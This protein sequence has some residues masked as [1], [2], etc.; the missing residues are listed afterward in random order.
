MIVI[1]NFW[2]FIE[3][4]H[5]EFESVKNDTGVTIFIRESYSNARYKNDWNRLRGQLIRFVSNSLFYNW[6]SGSFKSEVVLKMTGPNIRSSDHYWKISEPM[7]EQMLTSIIGI[8]LFVH[9]SCPLLILIGKYHKTLSWSF[10]ESP[11]I[12]FVKM[13]CTVVSLKVLNKKLT[14]KCGQASAIYCH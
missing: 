6:E 2:P 14:C 12:K 7:L 1:V 13:I 9:S 3:P 4:G 11:G 10:I 8:K 5:N